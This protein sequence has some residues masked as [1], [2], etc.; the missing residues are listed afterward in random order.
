MFEDR[1]EAGV[2]LSKKLLGFKNSKKTIICAIPRGGVVVGRIFAE[3]LKLPL[4]PIVVKKIGAPRNPELAIGAVAPDK[5]IYWDKSIV[6]DLNLSDEDKKESF[7][8]AEEERLEKEKLFD[9]ENLDICG[10]SI[11]VTDDG[12]ATG[13]TAI[14]AAMFLKRKNAS[15][16]ILATPVISP[17]TLEVVGK[18]YDK[19]IFLETPQFFSAVGQFYRNFPQVSNEEVVELLKM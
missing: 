13:S 5:V 19:I 12:V 15:R 17:D 6:E 4:F 3:K 1:K 10:K 7:E 11:I 8:M 18:Y 14:A 2:L 9:V 16:L